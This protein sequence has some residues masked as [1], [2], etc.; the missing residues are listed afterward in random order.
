MAAQSFASSE[1]KRRAAGRCNYL[2]CVPTEVTVGDETHQVPVRVN[3]RN[4]FHP[5]LRENL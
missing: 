2:I 3:H 5:V 1:H 4:P